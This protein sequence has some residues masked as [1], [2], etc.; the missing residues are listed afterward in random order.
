MRREIAMSLALVALLAAPCALAQADKPG[1]KLEKETEGKEKKSG[2]K[3]RESDQL[4][5]RDKVWTL[6]LIVTPEEWKKIEPPMRGGPPFGPPSAGGA[7]NGERRGGGFMNIDFP[8]VRATFEFEG[9]TVGEIGLRYKGASTYMA[10]R[11][12]AKKSY[13]LDFNQFVKKQKF[14]G[15]TKLNLNNNA[16]DN[17][18]LREALSYEIFRQAGVPASRTSYARVYLS[19]KGERER[20][21]LGLYT[22]VEQVDER[23]LRNYFPSDDGLLLKPERLR[24]L[25]YYGEDWKSYVQPYDAKNDPAPAEARRFIAFTKLVNEA[26]DEEFREQI[27]TFINV[28]A[29]MRFIAVNGLLVNMDSIL[30]MGQNYYI[31]HDTAEDQ[32]HW[33]PWD[34]NMSFGGFPFGSMEQMMNLSIRRP[35]AGEHKLIDRL[36]AM[37]EVKAAYLEQVE[38]ILEKVLRAGYLNGEIEK[39]KKAIRPAIAD[40]SAAALRAFDRALAE[41]MPANTAAENDG[42]PRPGMGRPMGRPMGRVDGPMGRMIGSAPLKP[43]IARRLEAVREQLAGNIEGYV[44]QFGGPGGRGGGPGG[45]GAGPGGG[46]GRG[47]GAPGGLPDGMPPF[48]G[49]GSLLASPMLQAADVNKDGKLT[50]VESASAAK[51]WF[52]EWDSAKQRALDAEA[53][54]NDLNKLLGQAQAMLPGPPP[55][56]FPGGPPGMMRGAPRIMLAQSF[57]RAGDANKDGKLTSV[58]FN[59][60]FAKWFAQWDEDKN[61]ALSEAEMSKGLGQSLAP[62]DFAEA[63]ASPDSSTKKPVSAP[64]KRPKSS[65]AGQR[66]K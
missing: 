39:L 22:I 9:Q 11:N 20:Q 3:S 37:P 18:Q 40:E 41:T 45:F 49:F 32:F 23:M 46:F 54:A 26:S 58:E 64:T 27:R 24:G 52:S 43:F 21:Y 14:F 6:H 7:S 50:K 25:P 31:Y 66:R 19:V 30:A 34:L 29:F 13:K 2:E 28:R 62:P 47:L 56:N 17:S 4:F 44:T 59:Q 65:R 55:D 48:F 51:R 60:A 1:A 36:L 8:E 38:E 53:L 10:A 61:H 33:I 42:F 35:H 15:L 5:Q 12:S 16:L 63:Q 57:L